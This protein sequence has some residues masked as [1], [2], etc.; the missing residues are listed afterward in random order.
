MIVDCDSH[1][2]EGY[3]M[4]EVYK[5]EGRSVTAFWNP[6]RSQFCCSKCGI[7][8]V[9]G[10]AA[11]PLSKKREVE[12]APDDT[13]PTYAEAQA[14]AQIQIDTPA[15]RVQVYRSAWGDQRRGVILRVKRGSEVNVVL[16]EAPRHPE[17]EE[18]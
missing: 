11:W 9:L 17:G 13:L 4:D 16:P 7:R 5:L 2:R 14:L 1:L 8:L 18:E 3:V 10:I 6:F 12:V 15:P